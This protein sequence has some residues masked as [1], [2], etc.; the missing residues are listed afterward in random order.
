MVQ[1]LGPRLDVFTLEILREIRRKAVDGTRAV[2]LPHSRE[3]R[4]TVCGS[5]RGRHEVRLAVGQAWDSRRRVAG[6]LSKA[7]RD[8]HAYE[9]GQDRRDW[10]SVKSHPRASLAATDANV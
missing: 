2:D 7:G 5:G 3:V 4:F 10:G 9:H 8:E 6:P 1:R